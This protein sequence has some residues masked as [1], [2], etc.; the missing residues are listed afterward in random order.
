[1]TLHRAL[2]RR[3]ARYAGLGTASSATISW[4]K[5]VQ[6]PAVPG[7]AARSSAVTGKPTAARNSARNGASNTSWRRQPW[8]RSDRR[9]SASTVAPSPPAVS[10][11]G[12]ART[13]RARPG[14]W[15]STRRP[16]MRSQKAYFSPRAPARPRRIRSRIHRSSSSTP[17]DTL[18]SRSFRRRSW[19]LASTG[20]GG[21]TSG[22]SA[23]GWGGG[24]ALRVPGGHP[25]RHGAWRHVA[26]RQHQKEAQPV[27]AGELAAGA[28]ALEHRRRAGEAERGQVGRTA[29]AL[30]AAPCERS[31]TSGGLPGCGAAQPLPGLAAGGI[32]REV[33]DFGNG[34]VVQGLPS[35]FGAHQSRARGACPRR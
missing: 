31:V 26:V 6:A 33:E 7:T 1:M 27:L 10:R 22:P 3:P 4:A 32:G 25:I 5:T 29:A 18:A 12:S 34:P 15:A 19:A 17:A 2:S 35:G 23:A 30:D 21:A 8:T 14:A 13:R 24:A 11:P 9:P 16:P 20:L 28:G